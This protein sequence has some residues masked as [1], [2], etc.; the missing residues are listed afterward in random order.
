MKWQNLFSKLHIN[1]R[2]VQ[3]CAKC[4]GTVTVDK[5]IIINREEGSSLDLHVTCLRPVSCLNEII[6]QFQQDSIE[7]INTASKIY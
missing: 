2:T 5:D 7:D 4:C 3:L 1:K 6:L